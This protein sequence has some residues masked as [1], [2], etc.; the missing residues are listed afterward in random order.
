MVSPSATWEILT[1]VKSQQIL[2][3]ELWQF[4]P[5]TTEE[6]H[7]KLQKCMR[8]TVESKHQIYQLSYNP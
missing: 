7:K 3:M 8:L 4:E 1:N 6:V 2:L 5:D